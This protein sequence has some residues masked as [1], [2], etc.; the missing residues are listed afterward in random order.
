[1]RFG[2]RGFSLVEV[3]V[4]MA[5][6]G[7]LLAVGVSGFDSWITNMRVRATADA[8][9]SGL[10]LARAEAI[11]RNEL[12][13]FQIVSSLGS[14]CT[15][16]GPGDT[17]A[18]ANW[19][20]SARSPVGDCGGA[21]VNE[22]FAL[23]DD[24]NNPSPKIIQRRSAA[25]GSRSVL[26]NQTRQ[27]FRFNGLGRLQFESGETPGLQLINVVVPTTADRKCAV[28]GGTV[29]CLRIE[30]SPGGQVRMCDPKF[31]VGDRDPQACTP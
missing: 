16:Y 22:A 25:E 27:Q 6:L 21:I 5:V 31:A 30:V 19:V 29:R 8:I 28:L 2:S 3:A 17:I 23:S 11:R 14:D 9:S 18:S 1:M 10:N 15:T 7:V 26:L 24:V 13:R 4:A 20:V 12:I